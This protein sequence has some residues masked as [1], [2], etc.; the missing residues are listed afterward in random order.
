MKTIAEFVA[1]LANN[2]ITFW[3]EEESLCCKAPLGVIDPK[4]KTQL[5]ERK[6]EIIAYLGQKS[7]VTDNAPS[8]STGSLPSRGAALRQSTAQPQALSPKTGSSNVGIHALELYFPNH[9][10]S[11]ADMEK[12]HN[13]EGKYTVGLGQ[14]A[15]TFCG[16]NEDAISMALTVVH[17]LMERYEIDWGN[18][19]RLEVGT[20]SLVD[21]SKS[22]KTHLM[23]LF[24]EHGYHDVEGVDSYNAC[25]GGTA[26]LFNTI[27]WCQSEAWDGRYGLVVCVDIADLNEEQSFLNGAAAV[28]MLIGPDAP[29]V[30]QRERASHIMHTWDFYKPVGWKDSF[31]LMRDGK[32]SI[33][34][35]LTCLDGCQKALTEKLG[36]SNL[37]RHDDYFVFHCTSTYLCKRAFDYLA[38]N[39]E[40][41]ISLKERQEL[42]QQKTNPSS[43]ITKQIGSTYTASCYVNLYSLLLHERERIQGKTI[44]VY[45]Y[46]SGATAS[47]YRLKVVDLPKF[48]WGALERLNQRQWYAPADFIKL[49]QDYSQT[50]G[51]FDFKPVER[52]DRLSGVYYLE[53]VDEWGRRYYSRYSSDL[54]SKSPKVEDIISSSVEY[55]DFGANKAEGRG[56]KGDS[57]SRMQ[58]EG[59]EEGCKVE[60]YLGGHDITSEVIDQRKP[61]KAQTLQLPQDIPD[62]SNIYHLSYGQK[63]L[64]FLW[65]LAPESHA[66]NVSAATR[67]C[68]LV[69]IEAM[70]KAFA[71]LIERHSILRSTFPQRGSEPVY[72]VHQNQELDFLVFD[73]SSWSEE[74]LKAK[75]V[76]NHQLPFDLERD[77]VM[78]VRWFTLSKSEHVMLLTIHHIACDG[79]SIDLLIQEL[80]QLY[81]SQKAGVEPSLPSLKHCY[82]DYVRWQK[83]L[84]EGA[85]G[86]KLWNYWQ[87]KL[88]GDLPV[89]NL[90]TDR[91]RSPVQTYNGASSKFKLSDKLTE[92]LKHLAQREG[93][94]SYVLLL[95]A[96]QIL[97]YRYTAQ[98][99]ILV[100]SPTSGRSK[101]EF[102]PLLGY[103]V[104]PVVMRAKLS[105]NPSFKDFLAQVRHTVLEALAH[106]DYPFALLV[107]KLQPHRDPSRSPIFQAS[108]AL[109]QFK[110]SRVIQKLF[111]NEIENNLDWGGLKLRPFEIPQRAGLFDLFLEMVEESSSIFGTF[112]YNTDLFDESTIEQMAAHYQN[113]LLEITK[114]PQQKVSGIPFLTDYEQEQLRC[115]SHNIATS[116]LLH[117]YFHPQGSKNLQV[118]ILDNHQQLVPLGVE[119]E[120]YLGNSDLSPDNLNPKP[121]K[122]L[123][124][125]EH[126]QL[127]NLLKTGEWGRRRVDGSLELLGKAH[128][129]VTFKGQRINLQ[130]IEQALLT[131]KGVEDCHVMIRHQELVAYVIKDGS[132]SEDFLHNH[133]KSQL[134]DYPFSYTYV[135]VSALPLTNLGEVDEAGLATIGIIDAELIKNWEEQIDSHSEIEQVAVVVQPNVKTIPPLHIEELLP[136]RQ[137]VSNQVSTP[138]KAS[139]VV[140]VVQDSSTKAINSPA[141]SHGEALVFPESAPKTLGEMLEQTAVKFPKQEIIYLNADGAERVQSYAQLLEDA[142][143]ILG[144]LREQGLKPQDKVIFQLEQNQDFLSA[145]W[146]CV[147][148][149]FIPVPVEVP[150]RYDLPNVNLNK[151]EN[152]WQILKR[153][154]V[155]TDQKLLPELSQWSQNLN[156]G[157]FKLNTIE[158]LRKFSPDK[159]YYD[160]QPEDIAILFLTSGS[161]GIPKVV[162]LSSHNLLSMTTGTILMNGFNHQDVTLNWMPMD[163]VGALVFLSIMAVDLGCQQIH[164]S[165]EYILQNPLNWLD[166]IAHHQATISWAPNFAFT[167]LCDRAE[168]ISRGNWNL[169]SMRFL[170][171]AGEAVVAKTAR[172]FLKLLGQHGLPSTSLHPA[173]GMCETCS[174]ITWSNS[175][176]LETTSDEDNFVSV[177]PP[178][179]GASVRI[180]DESGQV[181][182]EG[183]SGR[184]QLQ[185]SSVTAGYYQN[186]E[187][188]SQ[189]FNEEG[190]F[191]TGDLGFLRDN[192]LTITGRDKDVIII[193]GL[194]YYSHEIEAAVEELSSV[195]V[196]YTAAC[197]VSVT[198]NNT[199]E[200][201]IFFTP[202][203]SE[204]NQLLELLKKI[205]QQVVKHCGINPSYLIPVDQETIPKT[206]I[207]KIQRS[208]LKQRFVDGEFKPILKQVDLL[209]R[210]ANTIPNWF[211]R[212]VWQI[213]ENILL[214]CSPHDTLTLIFADNLGLARFLIQELSQQ[215]QPYVQ[216]TIG[217][218]FAQ[219]S[220]NHYS[221]V[222][223]NPQ[224]Y[225]LL[226]D[227]LAQNNQVISQILHLWDYN[228]QS[229]EISSL[230]HLESTQQQGI[231]SLLFLV[232]ALEQI[233]GSQ[234]AIK[235]L[236]I[237]N[238][239]QSVHPV[240]E[241]KPHK[242]T[243][244]GLLKTVPQE[245]PWLSARHLDLP[246]AAAELNSSYI[247][248]E[249]YAADQEKE[250][251]FRNGKRLVSRLESV[252]MTS[253]EKQEVP[254]VAR[255]TYLLT[256]GLG[257]IGTEIAAYLLEHYQARLILV[258]RTHLS[259]NGS[260]KPNGNNA[261]ATTKL[262][263]YHQLQQ[264]PGS[265][266]YEAVDICDLERLQQIVG[267]ATSE[268]GTQLNGVLHLAGVLQE[269]PISEETP[270]KVA[271]VLRAKVNGTWVLHQLLQEQENPLFLH[272]S[273]VNGFFGGTTVAAY[274]AANSFQ[275]AFADY[276]QHN[277]VQSYCCAWSMWHETGMSQGYQFPELSRA[278]GY[279]TIAPQQGIY[280]FLAALS[281]PEH[282]LLIGLDGTKV[283]I[284]RLLS[285]CQPRQ[286]LTAYFTSLAP[287]F[288]LSQLQ[289]LD[290]CDR[291]GMPSQIDLIQLKQMPLSETGEINRQQL[292]GVH[293]G[294][295]SD[296]EIKPNHQI[297][298]QLVEIFQEVLNLTSVSIH[299]NFFEI[300]GD[301]ILSIQVVSRA[302]NLG[303]E[304]TPKQV[305]QNQTIAE[306][307]RVANTTVRVNAQ[308]GIV[309]GVAPLTPIQHW[310]LAENPPAAHH[311]NQSVLLQ[312]P[313]DII[314]DLI[315][316]A[317]EK[318][319]S[320]HDALR[321]RFPSQVSEYQ[322]INQ[323][324]D[325]AVPFTVIDLS[326]TPR[327]SQPQALEQIA[328]EYQASLNLSDGPSMQV[329]MFNL[330]SEV[331]ARLLI[332]IHHLA[333]DGVS[334]RILLSDL[335]TIYQQLIAQQPIQLNAKTT[336]FIDWAEKLSN[337]AQSETSIQELDYWLK[338]PWSQISPLPLDYAQTQPENTVGNAAQVSVKL[339]VEE[340][341]ALLGSV[342]EAYNTQINDILLSA[343]AISLAEWTG[344]STIL[345]DL[346][347]H[348]REELFE[349]VDLSR[350]VGWFTSLFP[351]L[352]ELLTD[353]QPASI[354]KSIKEQLRA[355]P[356]R[357]IGYGIL[358][359]LCKDT[360]VNQQ[361]QSIPTP[362]I[363]FNY[364]GQFDQVTSQTGWKLASE[365][366]GANQSS[367]QTRNHLLNIIC[368]VVGGELQIDWIYSSNIHTSATV[369]NLVQSYVQAIRSIIK[370]C[371]SEDAFGYTPSDFPDT[372]LNQLE[373]DELLAPIKTRNVSSIYPLSSIQQGILFHS[374][375]TPKSGVYF[376]Q[377]TMNLKGE[378]NVA[379]FKTAWQ[380]VV[381]RHPILRS[382]FVWENRETPL[383]I[384][385]KQADLPWTNLDWQGLSTAE[386][387]RQ[388]SDL[389]KTRRAQGFQ[390]NQAPLME[391]SLI[392]LSDDTYKFIW[393]FHHIL[394]DG[395]S[396]PIIFK[397]VLSFY[398]A[399]IREETCYLPN[400]YPYRDYLA[401]WNNQDQEAAI[402]FWRQTLQGFNTPTPLVVDKLQSPN[403]QQ[404]NSDYQ[405]FELRLPSRVL[406]GLESMAQQYHVTLSTI[407]QA[408]WGLLL[409]RYSGEQD[410][411]FGVV[412]SSRPASLSGVENM[413]GLFINTLPLRLQIVPQQQLIPWLKQIQELIVELQQYSYTPLVEIQD[414]SELPGGIPLFESIVGFENYPVD[415]S[416]L[417]KSGSLQLSQIEESCEQTNYPLNIVVVPGDELLVRI[418][419]DADRFEK[420]AIERMAGHFQNLLSAIVENPQQAVG[421]LPLLSEAERHQLLVEWNDTATE[422]SRDKCIYQLFE[423][424]VEKTPDAVAVVFEN[425]QL[426]YVQLN[427]RANQLAH[428]LL[429]LGVGPDVLVGIYVER[430]IEMVVGLLGILKAGG[431]YV[432]LDPNYP[433]DRLS[434]MLADSGVEVLLS[435]QEL[436]SSLPSHTARVVC[437]DTDW[438]AI[439]QHSHE[440]IEVGVRSD[441][442]AYVIYTSG[443]T[444]VPKGVLVEH[445]NVVR[446]FAATQS[447]Y[448]FNA[449]D[450]WTNFHSIAFDF[451]V[452]EIWGALFYGGRL[453]IVPY[454][455][456]RD[457]QSFYDLLCS[458]NITVL[459]QTPSAF[460]Q[461]INIEKSDDRQP[462][463]SLRLVIF[464]GEAL[465]LQSLKPWFEQHGDKS[466]QL[467]N[468]YG[469]TETTVHVTYRA[470]TI[471]DLDSSG[472]AIGC[473]IPDV[474]IYILDDNLQPVPIGVKGQMYVGG[475]GVARGYLNRQQLSWE[476]FIPNPFNH[477][478]EGR[479]YKTGDVARYFPNGDIEYLGRIDNQVKIRG[480]RIELG[481]IEAVLNTHPQIQQAVVIARE[482]IP[483]NKRLVAYLVSED[484]SLSTNQLREFLKQKLPEYMLPAAFV[485]LETLLLTPN[486]KVDRKALPAPDG[487]IAREREYV[488]PQTETE[489]HIAAVLKEV[490][491]LEKV[492]IYDNFFDLGANS[493]TLVTI[494]TKLREI[495]SIELPVIDM[496][497]YPNIKIL[498]QHIAKVN[499][500]KPLSED[501][502]L[503]RKQ[504]KSSRK[505]RRQLRQQG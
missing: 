107:E 160:S 411:V 332:I 393:N 64:W 282:N 273:S 297:E 438:G 117:K 342:N 19:G 504:I 143:R 398:E 322:Q 220:P 180:V 223:G 427:Q 442:L 391:C 449:N 353:Y 456:S 7:P 182:E 328:T 41:D 269:K 31:P 122:S 53:Q 153:P 239:S 410:I 203:V 313:N 413:V 254:I 409:S 129:I 263:R 258:G 255:G 123:S 462:Q 32:H 125:I 65:Q 280:S 17:R 83:E 373:L 392:K 264:L 253:E 102:A 47:A 346:E 370:H 426:T 270:K 96:F 355:I 105:G 130:S 450:V 12:Y 174:G 167:L 192:C 111:V 334:W 93:V 15:V 213:K 141:I 22:I 116:Y 188:N 104:D 381:D 146:G 217:S 68:A 421:E 475:A 407:V 198:G 184:V 295:S 75:V 443:S 208:Q 487:E 118:Y 215:N 157:N 423:K 225:C 445:K 303:I 132:C 375:Y 156:D 266:I 27:A 277:G 247:W 309:T 476:R 170:V 49:T 371:Q 6:A 142:Q 138:V 71:G 341:H 233:Q 177:G 402:E 55:L 159:D 226:M 347:G 501:Y 82:Q 488:P 137:V 231:Y 164:T 390:L 227:S 481:E 45:S 13:V 382:F 448:H 345:I 283:N 196:S 473:P 459:N 261:S 165:T 396:L 416:L 80:S 66:Y 232:Q 287:K 468:M 219:I 168:E 150:A 404:Q 314:P 274:S 490:L 461:L 374:I 235:L 126:H 395:W 503:D 296:E 23:S 377:M 58:A 378:V 133:L 363:S 251:A 364:L 4:L 379:A 151:L 290:I 37:L 434:Y 319:L 306:L 455:S 120:I 128:R 136:S 61:H 54:E 149:G 484:K 439:E 236:W 152:S 257:G 121:E 73:A 94:T 38:N 485:T 44:C 331:D 110:K 358:R 60:E 299:D 489:K 43:L 367:K 497:T 372:Q 127:G 250:V 400:P 275:S 339:S 388:L 330:G 397:E 437:L 181:V 175:F 178:I 267:K 28:A 40:P 209:L 163:H 147:L 134:P 154:L 176:S 420:G 318:L 124:L 212:K 86:E 218:D 98:E 491:Q 97:L 67:I 505:K 440:N 84:L 493:L 189:S 326:S 360:A 200:L 185:G 389:L 431:A 498:S 324:L 288:S 323:G 169:S 300:G 317:L 172:N 310:F 451:S 108:F 472:S 466:P 242:A 46:G 469:I 286:K 477:Q 458:E 2:D 260:E 91:P 51:R 88:G 349:D 199:E 281:H 365:S 354:L 234:Q 311:F 39:A 408:A 325:D 56:R 202:C 8:S 186:P 399:E 362:E 14:K 337:Y 211:Y 5:T 228:E 465:E 109:T 278:K 101:P 302:K 248:Q 298:R 57:V 494:N 161:T 74:E 90:P 500:P 244:L 63:A 106:Q 414:R 351:V 272:F 249:I 435:Q 474:Q 34:V 384:A 320:H 237:A 166:L 187:A 78:R 222:P 1:D 10:V 463:L 271:A 292:A 447:W 114:N 171:N 179:A 145:F 20:E 291:F 433:Q 436:L 9:A 321:L 405:L 279:F 241:I 30:M 441:N 312:I 18:I 79:W 359:Y 486:G 352:L 387:Q 453:V 210:N 29:M 483:G 48:D 259:E 457:P 307:A 103:F 460:R 424:Q 173:F 444:G 204:Q 119:G 412:V 229:E 315:E 240:D 238:N 243:V 418:S 26:A 502:V 285:D 59:K 361:I 252:E 36:I 33:D 380:K 135:P 162:P 214:N 139:R 268:W 16:D 21:R 158:S 348:G 368:L 425:Q 190:W 376:Q 308:Q 417:D 115:S 205:R 403:Q 155:L 429:S 464:G 256:G 419:Y 207:G 350:T 112:K 305:F 344:N 191:I 471:K 432:P 467:V 289:Q 42:Y 72:Q 70:H 343:L 50:Y 492:G 113:L 35:Y 144:G 148:G 89:L 338:Q 430:S 87:E 304:I 216:I 383:Q 470:L 394:I 246:L 201:A 284:Q 415:S 356:N 480:F 327:D 495:L 11:Q 336:A 401:W 422:Y 24:G 77:P 335:A 183:T 100:G 499:T 446:L 452:W 340:T 428:H 76:E 221:L 193:N 25:Y 85:K 52:S 206:S 195:E 69:D 357:G 301:S 92:Q 482:D 197:G 293:F 369:E 99:D 62:T 224:H 3:V 386:Q 333:V 454:W 95:A 478:Q 245:M 131:A 366:T 140:E 329:V 294:W 81:Q 496:F 230:E 265:V 316:K 479:L 194:N 406:R 276:Q 262:E 385:L